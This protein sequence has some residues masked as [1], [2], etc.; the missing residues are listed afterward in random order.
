MVLFVARCFAADASLS[1]QPSESAMTSY[2]TPARSSEGV[3]V[4]GLSH[5]GLVRENNQDHFLV[6]RAS[7]SLQTIFTNLAETQP[8]EAFDEAGYGLV[9]ADGVGGEAAGEF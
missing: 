7:R 6:V 1:C 9:V 2:Q 5:K 3:D 4:F 8:G